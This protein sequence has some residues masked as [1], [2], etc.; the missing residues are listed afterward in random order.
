MGMACNHCHGCGGGGDVCHVVA[1]VVVFRLVLQRRELSRAG[2]VKRPYRFGVGTFT[3]NLQW[4]AATF[5]FAIDVGTAGD[6]N[7]QRGYVTGPHGG[8]HGQFWLAE[9]TARRYVTQLCRAL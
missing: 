2:S 1:A 5:V 8:E 3:G 7:A 6:R 9:P 4:R